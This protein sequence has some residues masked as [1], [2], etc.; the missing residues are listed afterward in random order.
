MD[1]L[2]EKEEGDEQEG[3]VNEVMSAYMV[4][5]ENQVQWGY[6]VCQVK[7]ASVVGMVTLVKKE[8]KVMKESKEKMDHQAYQVC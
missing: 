2:V 6:Q 3:M 5:K 7:K 1:H 4:P 8:P